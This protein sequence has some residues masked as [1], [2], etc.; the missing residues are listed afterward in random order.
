MKF[1]KFGIPDAIDA[2]MSGTNYRH[3]VKHLVCTLLLFYLWEALAEDSAQAASSL[4]LVLSQSADTNV[5]GYKIYY[6]TA[7]H[8]YTN[9][10]VG[11]ATNAV[12]TGIAP[13]LPYYFAAATYTASGAESPLSSEV[14]YTIPALAAAS[15]AANQASFQVVGNSGATFVVQASSNLINWINVQTNVAPFTFVDTN[16]PSG[17]MRFYRTV[18]LQ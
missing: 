1:R 4:T 6:G 14:T 5:I 9:V 12:I 15:Y 7:S 11:S 10:V 13:G 18:L 8:E 16:M 2:G 3:C 17:G